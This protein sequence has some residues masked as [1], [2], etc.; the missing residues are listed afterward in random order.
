[1]Q[2]AFNGQIRSGLDT[3]AQLFAEAFGSADQRE[4]MSAFVEK[5][6]PNF[7]GA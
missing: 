7:T 3:E 6:A 2:I 4:G 1:M 5:R